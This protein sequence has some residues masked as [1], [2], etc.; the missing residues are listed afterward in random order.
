M[1]ASYTEGAS[2]SAQI[3]RIKSLESVRK[4]FTGPLFLTIIELPFTII[5]LIAIWMLT[6]VLVVIPLVVLALFTLLIFYYQSKIR[7]S[8]R[9]AAIASSHR[10]QHGM[11][12]FIKMHALHHNGMARNWWMK[13]KEKLSHS[14]I[15][16]FNSNL[17]SS[18][19]ETLAHSV[20][21][22]SGLAIVGFGVHLI[23]DGSITIGALV[24][25]MLL[26]WRILGPLQTMCSMLP[27]IEQIKNSIA[28]INRLVNVEIERHPTVLKRPIDKLEGH[29]RLTNVGL[30]YSTEVEPIFVGLDIDVQ[31]GEVIGITGVNGSGKSSL[32]KLINGLYRPQTGT[33]RI[34]D[35]NIRQLEPIELR[36]YIA[37][38]PQMP[39]FFEGTI[40]EN[41]LLVNPLA[42]DEEI[43]DALIQATAMDEIKELEHGLETVI[44]G[45]NPSLPSGFIYTLNLARIFL[46]KS[47]IILLDELPN[48]SLNEDAGSAYKKLIS[49]A[50]AQNKT[51][52]FVSQR[53]DYIKL[54]DRVIVLRS[55]LRPTIMK[56]EEFINKYG[57]Y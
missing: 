16:S 48:A 47:N 54:A 20:S 42:T 45:N 31:A 38:L 18:T 24:A 32:L 27:R 43:D 2:I 7:V 35:V 19:I 6:G 22:I 5:L 28:Q 46:K 23:W 40:K 44:Y 30:R 34:D 53:D 8:M 29:V 51:V 36:N 4:F 49:G 13:Y 57:Q 21:M 10:Q 55:G 56:S 17:I 12:T 39:S 9:A 52:F 50:K 25:T 41:L 1:K 33:I 37:Y 15:S 14:S 3:S 11:E 26:I